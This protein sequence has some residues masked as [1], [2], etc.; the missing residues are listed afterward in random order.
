MV[1]LIAAVRDVH[2]GLPIGGVLETMRPV[3]VRRLG[4]APHFVLGVTG[5]RG[6]P[7]PVVDLAILLGLDHRL[8]VDSQTRW[9]TLRVNEQQ[10]AISVDAVLGLQTIP[11]DEAH[12]LPPLLAGADIS[13]VERLEQRDQGLLLVL[14][15]ARVIPEN[16]LNQL[17]LPD[18]SDA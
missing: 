13:M 2:V 9:I 12:A 4:D 5:I 11:A 10:V 6:K 15:G 18:A 14:D 3:P 7:T 8:P 17:T 1:L 16:L